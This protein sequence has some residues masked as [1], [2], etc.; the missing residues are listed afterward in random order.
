MLA[1]TVASV[2]ILF[3]LSACRRPLDARSE[4]ASTD[5]VTP[6][7]TPSSAELA[8]PASTASAPTPEIT[9]EAPLPARVEH[10]RVPGD[11]A[12]SIVRDGEG[13]PP[14]IVFLP[15]MCSNGEAYLHT[16]PEAAKA[17]GGV[18]ALEGDVACQGTTYRTFSWDAARQHVRIEAA[19]AATGLVA[20]PRE[21]ITLVG[22]SQGAAIGEELARRWPERYTR[23]VLIGAPSALSVSKI[24]RAH[25]LVTMS[26]SRDV[27]ARM[28]S[29]A[30]RARA[31]GIPSLYLEMPECRHGGVADAERIFD[32]AFRFLEA[33]SLPT[34]ETATEVPLG[35]AAK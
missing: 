31:A 11:L 7:R 17:H 27:V 12:V 26:C 23:V 14:H 2:L 34:P 20:I 3:A 25:G 8:P 6:V 5:A 18:V 32:S 28:K 29:G 16:F 10:V 30:D 33:N 21:G 1:R 35:R 22:Y 9:P 4:S 24:R 13:R 19:L 15:G